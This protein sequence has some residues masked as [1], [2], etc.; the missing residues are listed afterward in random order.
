MESS[1]ESPLSVLG[2]PL[3]AAAGFVVDDFAAAGV[4]CLAPDVLDVCDWAAL[5]L[6]PGR[7]PASDVGGT[8]RTAVKQMSPI[9][10]CIEM[11]VVNLARSVLA[12][13][14]IPLAEAGRVAGGRSM[15]FGSGGNQGNSPVGVGSQNGSG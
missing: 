3:L 2:V 10:H 4:F 6:A 12:F 13:I 14:Y 8:V 9:A 5:E 7:L 1:G 11:R 15:P